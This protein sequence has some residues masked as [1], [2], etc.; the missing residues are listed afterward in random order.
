MSLNLWQKLNS[1]YVDFISCHHLDSGDNKQWAKELNQPL[2]HYTDITALQNILSSS[3]LWATKYRFLND[4]T[5]ISYGIELFK[6]RIQAKST[7]SELLLKSISGLKIQTLSNYYVLCFSLETDSIPMWNYYGKKGGYSIQFSPNLLNVFYSSTLLDL[8]SSNQKYKIPY[9][10]VPNLNLFK[11]SRSAE[12]KASAQQVIYDYNF[13]CEILDL[14][15]DLTDRCIENTEAYPYWKLLFGYA[16]LHIPFFKSPEFKY[17]K[18]FRVLVDVDTVKNRH[19]IHFRNGENVLIPY[20][21]IELD[22]FNY[23]REISISPLI[24]SDIAEE[25]LR[26][27]LECIDKPN[28]N[29]SRSNLPIRY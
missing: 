9:K 6:K 1:E 26:E 7:H 11:S 16:H 27:F 25:G 10:L 22:I 29:I 5:E 23:I 28:I 20:V 21:N 19:L 15:I 2:C 13:Q 24:N 18:E 17:E 12:Y 4:N 3:R 8:T 14:I